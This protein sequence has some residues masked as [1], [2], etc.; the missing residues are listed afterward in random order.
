MGWLREPA[1]KLPA[2]QKV[3]V[4]RRLGMWSQLPISSN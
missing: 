4:C 1:I 3:D 2:N